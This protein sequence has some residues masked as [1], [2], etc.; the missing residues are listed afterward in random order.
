[1]LVVIKGA[2]DLATAI[3][4]RLYRA[5]FRVV[6]TEIDVPTTVRRTVAFSQAVYENKA[7]V[8]DIEGV[9]VNSPKQALEVSKDRVAILIDPQAECIRVLKPDIVVDAIIAKK[10]IGTSI[11]DA[12]LVVGVGP[13]FTPGVDCHA[14]VET[15]R[16]H[17]LGRVYTDRPAQANTGVPGLIGGHSVDRIIR[18]GHS[19]SFKPKVEIG[20]QV[21]RGDI[22]G[23]VTTS[24]NEEPVFALIDGVVRGLLQEGVPVFCG[25]KA[26][27]VD[28]RCEPKHCLTVSDK[29][30]AI[31]GGVLELAT[32]YYI[33]SKETL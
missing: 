11:E 2:G 10:N 25:M 27:D 23:V 28:P 9:L 22:V 13:G 24:L 1:M 26:G 17:Y 20:T 5:G 6:M 4:L 21:K 30:S 33:Q 16:G 29:G 12:N 31:G 8:E 14:V 7:L 15:Q 19:G 18:T 3:A 32:K